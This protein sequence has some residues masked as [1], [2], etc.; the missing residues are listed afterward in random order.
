MVGTG[1]GPLQP[2][3]DT[4]ADKFADEFASVESK[5]GILLSHLERIQ[6]EVQQVQFQQLQQQQQFQTAWMD[7]QYD[8]KRPS[9]PDSGA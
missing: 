3:G 4:F 8:S 5:L 1:V 2:E 7:Q 6:R 9:S